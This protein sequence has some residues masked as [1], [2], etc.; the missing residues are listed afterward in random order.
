MFNL[1]RNG[2][3]KNY[4][5]GTGLRLIPFPENK[6]PLYCYYIFMQLKQTRKSP[7]YKWRF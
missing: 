3:H 1:E 5:K 6:N 4:L 7:K 2:K